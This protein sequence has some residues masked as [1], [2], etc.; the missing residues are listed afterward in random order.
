MMTVAASSAAS[1]SRS[2]AN[3]SCAAGAAARR[4]TPGVA[5]CSDVIGG[6]WSSRCSVVRRRVRGGTSSGPGI[7]ARHRT[8]EDGG[9]IE[10]VNDL[11]RRCVIGNFDLL[12]ERVHRE[13]VRV[14]VARRAGTGRRSPCRRSRSATSIAPGGTSSSASPVRVG[15]MPNMTQ[16]TKLAIEI[17]HRH[18]QFDGV[19]RNRRPA[20]GRRHVGAVARVAAGI[21]APFGQAVTSWNDGAQR[22][23]R[24]RVRRAPPS[25][26]GTVGGGAVV[27]GGGGSTG[28]R[29][30]RPSSLH[31]V[32]NDGQ[33]R[34][35]MSPRRTAGR[36]R[37]M[38]R[39]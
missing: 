24:R 15:L 35:A 29:M 20:Q 31:A 38:E 16:C 5:V 17:D 6:S 7:R 30:S 39:A 10:Q 19:D 25:P 14:R 13:Q 33:C 36:P 11:C 32:T 22:R 18:R 37:C 34:R 21:A 23:R 27:L 3:T 28:G 2:C 26:G 8:L 4:R 9:L 12:V 1:S